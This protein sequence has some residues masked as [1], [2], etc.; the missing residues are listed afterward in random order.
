MARCAREQT[1]GKVNDMPDEL[2]INDVLYVRA[3]VQHEQWLSVK[4]AAR[5]SGRAIHTVYDAIEAGDIPSFIPN[6]LTRGR[7]VRRSDVIAWM[8]T[9]PRVAAMAALDGGLA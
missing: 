3:D 6:G 9:D 8:R 4:E 5:M 2:V 7:K 1:N